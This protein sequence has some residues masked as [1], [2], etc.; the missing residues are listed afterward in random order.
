MTLSPQQRLA[1]ELGSPTRWQGTREVGVMGATMTGL[2]RR[3]LADVSTAG[4]L[5]LGYT[6]PGSSRRMLYRLTAAG[7]ELDLELNARAHRQR[8][9][10]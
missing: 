5:G 1:L 2:E 8:N 10:R 9:G 3:G 4:D 7:V 6:G